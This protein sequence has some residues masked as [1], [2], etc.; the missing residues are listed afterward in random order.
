MIRFFSRHPTAANLMMFAL[1]L[2]GLVSLPQI[3]R[4]TF[5]EFS[6]PYIIAS[7]VYPGASPQEVEQSI[8]MRMEDA[9]DGLAI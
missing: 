9:V 5:P 6:P 2:L 3:K 1:L 4:E 7:V 8:C